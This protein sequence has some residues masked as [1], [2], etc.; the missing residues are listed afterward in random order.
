MG[1]SLLNLPQEWTGHWWLP[2]APEDRVPGVL[3]YDPEDGI[4][5]RLIGGWEYHVTSPGATGGIVIHQESRAWP[6]VLGEGD[7]QYITVL[8]A[9]LL[10]AQTFGLGKKSGR[11]QKLSL[12]ASTILVG[13]HLTE[14]DDPEFISAE[15]TVENLT[16]WSRR[17]GLELTEWNK[18]NLTLGEIRLDRQFPVTA[19]IGNGVEAK[20]SMV[21]WHPFRQD[22][23]AE[24]VARLREHASVSFD[25]KSPLKLN[26]LTAFMKSVGDLLSL[27]TLSACAIIS[28]RVWSP[29]TPERFPEDHPMRDFPHEVVVFQQLINKPNPA[30]DSIEHRSLVL[31]L[32]DLSFGEL[33][34]RWFA[35]ADRFEAARSM[36]LGLR[37]VTGGYLETQVV[38]AVAA[39]ESFHRSLALEAHRI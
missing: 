2:D 17:S 35:Q 8:G 9:G 20:L 31:S 19:D 14:P 36:I 15:V 39:A 38:T 34:P 33:M 7:G 27:S 30:A 13:C 18:P 3:H 22:L 29:P 5:L 1:E 6:V 26:E 37:Y 32:D 16:T 4:E 28:M 23:R 25:G 10:K 12:Y 11:P 21:G 24:N